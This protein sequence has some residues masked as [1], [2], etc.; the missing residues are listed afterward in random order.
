[1]NALKHK[2]VV[3]NR[4]LFMYPLV[5]KKSFEHAS[6]VFNLKIIHVYATVYIIKHAQKMEMKKRMR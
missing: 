5:K 2:A 3:A 1:M 6:S 4:S